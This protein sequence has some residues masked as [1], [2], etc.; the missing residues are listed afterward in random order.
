MFGK[1]TQISFIAGK[2]LQRSSD[3][4]RIQKM[5]E[6]NT[7][8]IREVRAEIKKM[9]KE[10][11]VSGKEIKTKAIEY[12]KANLPK[13]HWGDFLG[14]IKNTVTPVNLQKVLDRVDKKKAEYERDMLAT[15]ITKIAD[16]INQ[17]P[18]DFQRTILDITENLELKRHTNRLLA[19]L[20][21]TKEYLDKRGEDKDMPRRVLNEL[22]ILERT[23]LEKISTQTL[24]D[25]N[26]KLI[27]Y[28][29]VGRNIMKNKIVLETRTHTELLA[30]VIEN[31]T[32][33]DITPIEERLDVF[34][35]EKLS[36]PER[37]ALTLKEL[38][39][40]LGSLDKDKW[41]IAQLN[42]IGIDRLFNRIDGRADYQGANYK[43][44][45]EPIDEGWNIWQEQED[46]IKMA[47]Y[48]SLNELK[49]TEHSSKRIAIYAYKQ[50][51]GGMEKL[52]EDR[53]MTKEQ[54]D[55][56]VL[57]DK[58][59]AVYNF[60]RRELDKLHEDLSDYMEKEH[61]I[62]LGKP[63]FYFPMFTDYG[64]T[65]PLLEEFTGE[66]RLTRVPFGS[67]K[68]RQSR[69]R[70]M[71]KL[72]AFQIFDSYV[73]KATYFLAM[74]STIAKLA[75]I[76]KSDTYRKAV[77]DN[78]QRA[79]LTWIDVL[80]RKGGAIAKETKWDQKLNEF[81]NNL[82]VVVL[83]LRLTTILKQPLALLDGAAEIG[84]YAFKGTKEIV[85]ENWRTFMFS[86]SSEM[87]NRAGGDPAFE[88]I[89]HNKWIPKIQDKAMLPIKFFDRYT[90][91]SVWVGA[92]MKKM[93]ELGLK[94]DFE[95]PNQEALAYANLVVRKTQAMGSFKDLALIMT[96]DNRKYG[97][98]IFKFQNF[99]LNRWAYLSEDLPDKFSH[100]KYLAA[101]QVAFVS[102]AM[103]LE[104]GIS[105]L[106]YSMFNGDDDDKKKKKG[107]TIRSQIASALQ[108][109]PVLGQLIAAL[110]YGSNP[111]PLIEMSN[112]LINSGRQIFVGKKLTTKEK[113]AIRVL[114]ITLGMWK[115]IPTEQARAI[116]EKI[117]F[118][119]SKKKT[120][121]F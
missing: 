16:N 1:G 44:F 13:K 68:E 69:A 81:N 34:E 96:A 82:S 113:H 64:V 110:N 47:F 37:K 48:K 79:V 12:V 43:I 92:Y 32:N 107:I 35:K 9:F 8:K 57:T 84:T 76:A 53:K 112:K 6:Q 74:D 116:L 45:K 70:Q 63:D 14:A 54:I 41:R 3:T 99:V 89:A 98:L 27:Q 4:A 51:R 65:K 111:L 67:M 40:N 86:N 115:G 77:G 101:R 104:G 62:I 36:E 18:V 72:D 39:K 87:R 78:A 120:P 109:I 95:K 5:R 117:L 26:N 102:L 29:N 90:A 119:D 31:A 24:I 7:T 93:D 56:I 60:M 106:Y 94:V 73:G 49:L 33:L 88:E 75:K 11:T 85:D 97:K 100:D 71:L 59:T 17:L 114:S 80:A 66:N 55:S 38:I 58:E 22:G 121:N 2:G 28:Y 61:E 118:G 91:G 42:L 52:L 19:R 21:R 15:N 30:K 20:Q 10:K 25:V 23:P 83:G 46:K 50:Q 108:T 105:S 103:I